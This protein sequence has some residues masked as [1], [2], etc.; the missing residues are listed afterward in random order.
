MNRFSVAMLAVVLLALVGA[1]SASAVRRTALSWGYL[2]LGGF[3][4]S[5]VG[6]YSRLTIIDFLDINN[7]PRALEADHVLDN[8]GGLRIGVG[9]KVGRGFSSGLT[10]R[11]THVVVRDSFLVRSPDGD[12]LYSFEPFKPNFNLY[13]LVLDMN[14]YPAA[15]AAGGMSVP[16]DPYVGFNLSGG[17]LAQTLEGFESELEASVGLGINFG[18]DIR[19]GGGPNGYIALSSVNSWQL[20]GS[21]DQPR[22]LQIGASLKFFGRI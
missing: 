1:E 13:E 15:R 18:A 7:I 6:S 9:R 20:L 3:H 8:S 17:I 10:F 22:Y 12:V 2:E 4:A 14:F 21:N 5:P 11:Y 19:L 16:I